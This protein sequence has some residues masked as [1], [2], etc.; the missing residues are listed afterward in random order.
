MTVPDQ[1]SIKY[2]QC[3]LEKL[4]KKFKKIELTIILDAIN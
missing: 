1:S 2:F 3:V 4:F